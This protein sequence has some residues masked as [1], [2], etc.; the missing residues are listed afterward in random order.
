MRPLVSVAVAVAAMM[1]ALL[2]PAAAHK[3]SDS[4]LSLRLNGQEIIGQWDVALRDLDYAIGLDSNNDGIITWGE[5]RNLQVPIAS[6]LLSRLTFQS[7][8]KPCTT[9]VIRH[10][11]DDHSDGAYEV[12]RFAADCAERPQILQ[13]GYDFFF[14]LDPQ[15][16]GLLRVEANGQT[17]P[18]VLSP[19]Q[20]TWRWEGG[21]VSWIRTFLLFQGGR[22]AH[23][24]RLRSHPVSLC[25]V[26]AR[27]SVPA[28]RAVDRG[29]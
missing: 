14:D 2:S 1:M 18:A 22:L 19:S 23:L 12:L 9:R 7:D 28:R 20:K 10:L 5:L 17:H 4:Y 29:S 15:H 13:I 25:P 8:G 16:R 21:S 11:V 6:Y 3:P 27:R 26:A 24:D